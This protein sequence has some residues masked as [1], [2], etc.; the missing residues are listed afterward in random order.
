MPIIKLDDRTIEQIAAGE[1]I[2]SPV[3]VV[4]E[5]VENSIDADA[6]NIVIEIKKGGKSYIRVTDDGRGIANDQMRLAF[7]KHTT[8]KI[9]DFSDLYD[10]YSLGFRGEALASIVTV[11]QVK[12]ISKTENDAIGKKFEF[13]NNSF[14]ESSIATNN[15]TSIEVINLFNNIPVRKKFLK[16]DIAES[17]AISKL[18]YSLAIGYEGLSLKYIKDGR[19]EFKTNANE[20]LN[21]R[22][23]KLLDK[24]LKDNLIKVDST[25]DIY[26]INGYISSSNYYRG[27]RNLQYLYV[28]NRLI[29][30]NL[31][32]KIIEKEYKSLIPQGRFPAFFLFLDTNPKNLDINVH[33]NKRTIKFNYEDKLISL[34][35]KTINQSLRENVNPN[36]IKILEKKENSIPDL[37]NYQNLLNSYSGFNI[38][39]E[40]K[41]SYE[42]DNSF[43]DTDN[44]IDLETKKSLKTPIKDTIEL[45]KVEETS[46]VNDNTFLYLT[47]IFDRYSVFKATDDK[48]YLMDHRRADQSI[49]FHKY[50]KDLE[51]STIVSQLL[52]NP[53][54]INLKADEKLRYETNKVFIKSLGFD[55]EDFG[56]S[57]LIVRSVPHIFEDAENEN[58]IRD[59]IDMDLKEKNEVFFKKIYKLVKDTSFRKGHI[60]NQET[61]EQLMEQIFKLENP[62]KSY[63]G[64]TVI[65]ELDEDT[66][67]K[68]FEK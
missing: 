18:M 8:S 4:K 39:R 9:K 45:D 12:A 2:E 64:K 48:I 68:Y 36:S 65:L 28:N 41:S 21:I 29:D 53:L 44:T 58:L 5:L 33:P 67:E 60:I 35:E 27:S 22:I 24:N 7:E 14:K 13:L 19:I 38:V 16:S 15:G 42:T 25:D 51:D 50:I 30:S 23:A 43:F 57:Q 47:S 37:T 61:A 63:D 26:H 59:L 56:N 34:I 20:P 40:E 54:I 11:S 10:I 66:L 55:I 31:I 32:T 49:K 1:V 3:S 46:F 17:N 6:K 62:Y 52:L